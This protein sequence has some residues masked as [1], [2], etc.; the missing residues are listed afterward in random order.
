MEL[1]IIEYPNMALE[2]RRYLSEF[3]K[4]NYFR[5]WLPYRYFRLSVAVV[6][7]CQHYFTPVHGLISQCCWNFNC[8]SYL[9]RH[10]YFR[11]RPPFPILSVIIGI[12]YSYTCCE[13]ATAKCRRFAIGILM[14]YVI[15]SEILLLPVSWPPSWIFDT[16]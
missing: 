6:L 7:I 14:I 13:F 12:A 5:F 1:D 15:V 16:R 2:F 11:F 3:H 8:L 9:K 4:C 10:K